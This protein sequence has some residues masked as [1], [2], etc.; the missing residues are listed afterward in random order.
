[1]RTAPAAKYAKD[2]ETARRALQFIAS[3]S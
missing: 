1:V 2:L 3:R